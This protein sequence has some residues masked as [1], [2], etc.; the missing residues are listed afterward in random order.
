MDLPQPGTQGTPTTTL[1]PATTLEPTT[2]E[3]TTT[4]ETTKLGR[5]EEER[6]LRQAAEQLFAQRGYAATTVDDIVERAGLSKPALYRHYESKKDQ[7]GR[8]HV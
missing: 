4:L 6:R 5:A 2:L 7:I 1:E 8:A 3:P